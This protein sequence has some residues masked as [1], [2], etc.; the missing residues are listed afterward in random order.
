MFFAVVIGQVEVAADNLD[1]VIYGLLV[2]ALLLALLTF[3][4]WRHTKPRPVVIPSATASAKPVVAAGPTLAADDAAVLDRA[5]VEEFDPDSVWADS[6]PLS[7]LAAAV[8]SPTATPI[9]DDDDEEMSAAEWLA[10]T[11]PDQVSDDSRQ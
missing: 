10:I 8:L 5:M 1:I 9:A 3:W 7:P 2:V 6:P 4:Y 11:G